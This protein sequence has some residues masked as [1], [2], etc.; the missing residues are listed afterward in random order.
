M[1]FRDQHYV[2]GLAALS[3]VLWRAFGI[4]ACRTRIWKQAPRFDVADLGV[5]VIG[6]IK[7]GFYLSE[8]P[9]RNDLSRDEK[10]L[11]LRFH[12]ADQTP[13]A[14]MPAKSA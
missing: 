12:S 3:L 5:L 4:E 9:G 7:G 8:D 10:N 11:L 14:M 6:V 2:Y 13:P 1:V